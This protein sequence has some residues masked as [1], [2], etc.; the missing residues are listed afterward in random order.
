MRGMR[1]VA[2]VLLLGWCVSSAEAALTG[3]STANYLRHLA[4]VI[5]TYPFFISVWVYVP[6][7]LGTEERTLVAVGQDGQSNQRRASVGLV[8]TVEELFALS[9]TTGS[10]VIDTN[11]IIPK[12]AWVHGFG[13]FT[14]TTFRAISMNGAFR[15][16]V[17]TASDPAASDSLKI[18]VRPDNSTPFSATGR[19]AEVSIWNGTGIDETNTL[20]LRDKLAGGD[21]PLNV[22]AEA[23]QQ[24]TGA[25][26]AYWPLTSATDLTDHADTFDLAMVGTLTTAAS[27]PTID[28]V[29]GGATRRV[30]IIN[31]RFG[32]PEPKEWL[33]EAYRRLRPAA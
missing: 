4:Q 22:T 28:P 2:V 7:G 16:S 12:D 32:F 26:V 31:Q 6:T 5:N 17:A 10:V 3:W 23:A 1:I 9:R 8:A 20:A 11:Q 15:N 18:G 13:E 25:L 33:N 14:S 21:N 24:W 30:I 27:H 29:A 19:I